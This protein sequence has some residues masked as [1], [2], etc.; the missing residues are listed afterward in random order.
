MG[1]RLKEG[2][3]SVVRLA[4]FGMIAGHDQ[5]PHREA[6]RDPQE[7]RE[8]AGD[9]ADQE[10]LLELA[11]LLVHHQLGDDV[12]LSAGADDEQEVVGQ[13]PHD[14]EGAPGTDRLGIVVH[15]R[16]RAAGEPAVD[17]IDGRDDH[18]HAGD[19]HHRALDD[20]GVDTGDDAAGHAVEDE[21]GDGDRHRGAEAHV[22][23]AVD[24]VQDLLQDDG[25]RHDLRGEVADD[26]ENDRHRGQESGDL[27]L[28]AECHGVGQ[29]HRLVHLGE[30]AQPLRHE[31]EGEATRHRAADDHPHRR[32]ALAVDE[33]GA[34]DEAEAGERAREERE[35]GDDDPEFAAGH[36]EVL[37]RLR[38]SERPD[39][40]ADAQREVDEEAGQDDGVA[41]LFHQ[42]PPARAGS[43]PPASSSF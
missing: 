4:E 24:V 26:A 14:A 22:R 29:R 25:H 11:D 36:E 16:H 40:D 15:Q 19:G 18:Q 30:D 27:A 17:G 10:D 6:D 7:R 1:V 9:R 37:G 20:I 13:R 33:T 35:G 31:E 41:T 2:V 43:L 23:H 39:A 21:D 28:V 3:G 32:H 42:P 12:G 8:D 5:R 34:A 38:A